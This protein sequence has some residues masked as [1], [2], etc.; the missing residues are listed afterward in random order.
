MKIAGRAW[1][2]CGCGRDR[3]A[4]SDPPRGAFF[5][6]TSSQIHRARPGGERAA[7]PRV[8][9]FGFCRLST[10]FYEICRVRAS[11]I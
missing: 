7:G 9:D 3:A 6:F 1:G 2:D 8:G 5:R 10:I 4:C 11:S